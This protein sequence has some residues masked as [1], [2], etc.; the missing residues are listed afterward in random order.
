LFAT[1]CAKGA[2]TDDEKPKG[3]I[4]LKTA[5]KLKKV[6]ELAEAKKF[7]QALAEIDE[8]SEGKYLNLYEKAMLA[9]ARAGLHFALNKGDL[10]VKDLEEALS[11]DAM[12]RQERLDATYNL[13]QAY[14]MLEQFSQSADAFAKWASESEKQEPSQQY[15]IASAFSQ[16]K[17]F[18]E[19][20][21]YAQKAVDGNP[22]APEPWLQLLVSLHYE[23]KHTGE[24][25]EA[26][27]LLATRYPTKDNVLQLAQT[28]ADN[29]D[30]AKALAA[31]E[32][33]YTKG[34]MSSEQELVGLA[35]MYVKAGQPAK[36]AAL[37]D[38]HMKDGKVS[39]TAENYDVVAQAFIA[40][41]DGDRAAAALAA[42]GEGKASGETWYGL[43]Q[44][45]ASK[46]HWEKAR[47]ALASAIRIGGLEAPGDAQ[48][49]LGISHFNTKRK[50]LA[51]SSLTAAK[52]YGPA[53]SQC[54][55]AWIKIV[56]SGKVGD[57][58]ECSTTGKQVA[59]Q[60]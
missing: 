38:K 48:L 6:R 46:G 49:L 47:D 32:P 45:E 20:L 53:T 37:L 31:A 23:L 14:F 39:K 58:A 50:D 25:A 21:P 34:Q 36:A 33:L 7:D 54:A 57:K 4:T 51:I 26:Q 1:A 16:A 11:Y 30:H 40:G 56:K 60:K 5:E 10:V 44:L 8:I 24:L 13:A 35:Q 28:Y 27:K 17:R 22:Q 15:L 43:G 29:G 55:D 19:G 41:N 42:A 3:S 59:A 12:S 18:E 52:K 2:K 9:Q